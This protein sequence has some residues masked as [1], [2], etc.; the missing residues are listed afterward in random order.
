MLFRSPVVSTVV[1][2]F[3]SVSPPA[4]AE[5]VPLYQ[6]L[7]QA[8]TNTES[9]ELTLALHDYEYIT[10]ETQRIHQQLVRCYDDSVAISERTI[11]VLEFVAAASA[12]TVGIIAGM[13]AAAGGLALEGA[14]AAA[15]TTGY[16]AV[17]STAR[18]ASEVHFDLRERIDWAG[19]TV[20]AF[21]NFFLNALGGQLSSGIASRIASSARL[22]ALEQSIQR[23]APVAGERILTNEYVRNAVAS[24]IANRSLGIV[25]I[26]LRNSFN[27]F[28]S[29]SAAQRPTWGTVLNQI[30]DNFSMDQIFF[31]LVTAE[32]SRRYPAATA[33]PASTLHH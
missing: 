4:A 11:V 24:I 8:S 31:D 1:E 2:L 21:I 25:Q 28:R 7:A 17:Q 12:V 14:S 22:I 20:D 9:G 26:I 19:L 16:G 5:F 29:S 15:L 10:R 27:S 32:V 30:A 3:S 33:A 23:V 6:R 18:Q 13:P